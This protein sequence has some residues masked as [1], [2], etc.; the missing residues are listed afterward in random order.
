MVLGYNSWWGL[1]I[2]LFTT[3]SRTVLGPTQPTV[4]WVSGALSLGVKQPARHE[5]DHSPPSSAKVKECMNLYLCSSN[6]PSWC[7]AQLKKKHRYNFTFAIV[8]LVGL[9][10]TDMSVEICIYKKILLYVVT[11]VT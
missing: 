4:Q 6:M 8:I 5:S 3:M 10:C 2:F 1:G 9:L 7:G 11:K